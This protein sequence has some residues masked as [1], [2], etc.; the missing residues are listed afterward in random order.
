MKRML[1][2]RK[3]TS[4]IVGDSGATPS[5]CFTFGAITTDHCRMNQ[6]TSCFHRLGSGLAIVDYADLDR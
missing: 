6:S 4:T 1:R 5:M 3:A 2:M